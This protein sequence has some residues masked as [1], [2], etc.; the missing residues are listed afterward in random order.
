MGGPC[1]AVAR[2]VEGAGRDG[3]RALREGSQRQAVHC[4][5]HQGKHQFYY[6]YVVEPC[7]HQLLLNSMYDLQVPEGVDWQAL[8]KNAMVS[9]LRQ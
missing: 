4:Q 8:V 1:Q 6:S 3:A 9:S 7:C 5:H 2:S